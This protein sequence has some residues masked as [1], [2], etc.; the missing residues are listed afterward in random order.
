VPVIEA[1]GY[2]PVRADQD[3][4]TLIITQILERRL[5]F[6]DLVLACSRAR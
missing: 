6:A 1:L 2:Q 3:T 4:G 5:Y